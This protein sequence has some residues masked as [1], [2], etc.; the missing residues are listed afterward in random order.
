MFGW[1]GSSADTAAAAPPL[2]PAA[3][4]TP[5]SRSTS[6][7]SAGSPAVGA[8][9]AA[10]AAGAGGSAASRSA[11]VL[12]LNQLHAQSNRVLQQAATADENGDIARAVRLYTQGLEELDC[13]LA[14]VLPEAGEGPEWEK[15]RQL[16]RS[17]GRTRDMVQELL[18]SR[19]GEPAVESSSCWMG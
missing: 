3:G 17:M 12:R 4:G 19:Q 1:F 8:P 6:A 15:A 9:P 16:Y 10:T 2:S 14:V 7:Q 11:E 5:A 18:T 13:A